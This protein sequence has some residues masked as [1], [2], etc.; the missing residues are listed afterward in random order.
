MCV[1]FSLSFAMNHLRH[2]SRLFVLALDDYSRDTVPEGAARP[3]LIVVDSSVSDP[4]LRVFTHKDPYRSEGFLQSRQRVCY[5]V[6]FGPLMSG[7]PLILG[8]AV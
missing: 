1:C 2:V 3:F 4:L 6:N 7:K 5:V 8:A